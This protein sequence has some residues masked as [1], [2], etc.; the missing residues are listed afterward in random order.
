LNAVPI[1]V[2]DAGPLITFA[3]AGR[4]DLRQRPGWPVPVV[5]RVLH[6]VTRNPT[7]TSTAISAFV[8][9]HRH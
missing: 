2:P 7:P 8:K 9:E 1:L 4:L 6:E 5:D 3:Y